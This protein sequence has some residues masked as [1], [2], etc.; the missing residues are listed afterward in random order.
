[1]DII[2]SKATRQDMAAVLT[3]IKEL[4]IY[5]KEPDAVKINED[6]LLEYGFGNRPLFTCF[7]A[8]VKDEVVGTAICYYRFSTW[9]GK[10]LHLEDLVVRES[11]RGKG[12][13]QKLYDQ[14][15]IYGQENDVKRVEWVVLDWN[16]NAIEFYE[17]SGVH[18]LKDWYLVQMDKKQL[19]NYVKKIKTQ[20]Q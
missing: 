13:G 6:D 20:D 2:I 15:M 14:V 10:S 5:E 16:S 8:K 1:M 3:L 9:Q 17:K 18:F 19:D 12:V 11:F 7:V 4:A